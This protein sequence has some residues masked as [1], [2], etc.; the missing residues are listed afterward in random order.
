[1]IGK[2]V[3]PGVTG[4][5]SVI[6]GTVHGASNIDSSTGASMPS[7]GD[8]L[9]ADTQVSAAKTLGAALGIDSAI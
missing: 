9:R 6:T 4:G 3:A 7:G 5:T 1:M 8:I 2:N